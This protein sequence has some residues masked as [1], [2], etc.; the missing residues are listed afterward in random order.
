MYA[1]Y[2]YSQGRIP[3]SVNK[4]GHLLMAHYQDKHFLILL[5]DATVCLLIRRHACFE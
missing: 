5:S 2:V 1:G 4:S 3:K